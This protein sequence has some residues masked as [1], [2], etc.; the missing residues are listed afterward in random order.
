MEGTLD[1]LE[2]ET[3]CGHYRRSGALPFPSA[4]WPPVLKKEIKRRANVAG[5]ILMELAGDREIARGYINHGSMRKLTEPEPMLESE[6]AQLR[7][8][9]LL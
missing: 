6:Q 3:S 5:S 2:A 7:L 4:G 9:S 1:K 8:A